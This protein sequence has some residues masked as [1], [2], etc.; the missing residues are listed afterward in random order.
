MR[1]DC[2]VAE[3]GS[4]TTVVNAFNFAGK[5]KFIG[6]G[7]ANTT[8]NTDVREGLI[9]AINELKRFLNV[10]ELSYDEMFAASSAAGGLRVTVSGLVYEMTVRAAKEAA[11]NAGANIHLVSAGIIEEDDLNQIIDIKPNM[12]IVAG[13]TDF[14]EKETAFENVK[15][16]ANLNLNVPIIYAGNVAN[17]HKIIEF[18]KTST[19]EGFLKIV[20]NVYPRVDFLNILPLRKVIY[21]TF[22]EHIIH[23]K[24]MEHIKDMV[25]GSIMPTPGSVMETS[26]LLYDTIGSLMTIDVGGATTDIHSVA[27]PSDEYIKYSEGEAKEKRT[28]EGDLG[29]FIN[30]KHVINF[31]EKERL[32]KKLDIN[33]E[34]FS[35][36]LKNYSYLPKTK[37]ERSFVYELTRTC[38]F[39][40]L[41][42]H[43]GDLKKVYTTNGQKMIP[44][45]KDLSQVKTII[46]TGGPLIYLDNTEQIIKD[47]I[48]QNPHK[49]LPKENV[50]ILKDTLYIMSSIG[51]LS[52]KHSEISLELLK[53]SL[54]F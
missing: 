24:G 16:V 50:K 20:E 17:H 26:M 49:L 5:T 21:Q 10:S 51:V 25:N 19:Q 13:G 6:K 3:I 22:E 31:I 48:R 38:V 8:V 40:A 42:R 29:V 35:E 23:A 54:K 11:L 1:I 9:E 15:K 52:L 18:F 37:L 44:E 36:L 27:I 28:V 43:A 2:L 33:E 12:I 47:Y 39:K 14:G 4:T 45:G 41:D 32:I 30:H 46:L 53:Q 7:V 34:T